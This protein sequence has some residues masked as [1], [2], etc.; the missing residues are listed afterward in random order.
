MSRKEEFE[1]VCN[2]YVDELC[3]MWGFEREEAHWIA[4][5]VGEVVDV[6]SYPIS[7]DNVRYIVDNK[8]PLREYQDWEEYVLIAMELNKSLLKKIPIPSFEHLCNG[9]PRVR[10]EYLKNIYSNINRFFSEP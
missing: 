9:V 2:K 7:F 8:V 5:R 3:K 6:N 1:L 4:D 10:I